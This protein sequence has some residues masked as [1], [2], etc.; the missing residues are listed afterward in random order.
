MLVVAAGG[1]SAPSN[2]T[3]SCPPGTRATA[4][5]CVLD[6]DLVL[7]DTIELPSFTTLDCRGYRIL[8][9]AVGSGTTQA[10]YIPSAPA[11]AIAITGERGVVVRNCAIGAEGARFDFGVI[12]INS[13]DAGKDGH[14][15]HNNEI[16]ARDSAITFLRVDDAR[17]NNNVITWTNGSGIS[18]ARDSDRNRVNNNVM[19]SPGAPPAAFRLVPGGTF[20]NSFDDAIFMSS[21]HLQPLFNL[22]IGGKLFQ[23]PNSENGQYPGNEDNF[24]GS[25]HLSL[26]GPS[27]GKSHAG[28][29]V[30]ANAARARLIGNTVSGAGTGIRLAG[31][32]PEQSVTRPGRCVGEPSRFCLTN[33]DC[34]IP[35]IDAAPV[36]TCTLPITEVR[37]LRARDTV[38][39]DNRLYGPFNSTAVPLRTAIFG[40]AGTV[41]GVIRG[42]LIYG[43][44]TEAGITLVGEMLQSGLVMG[45]AVQGASFGILLQQSIATSFDARV[46]LN[47]I[48]GSSTRAIGVFGTYTLPTELSWDGIGNYWG[49]LL[50]PCFN[51][52]DTP[53]PGLIQDSYPFCV[54]VAAPK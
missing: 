30:S 29:L 50:P 5:A 46:F 20:G 2:K 43:T 9:S 14:R 27:A 45:N 33:A 11:L 12:A 36:G 16:H 13:K 18:F 37:D 32:M 25:N 19:S 53:I 17:V 41:G 26:P 6:A 7:S 8:P 40:G 31:L 35:G 47:D 52:S 21:F 42:N 1:M 15:I 44:G 22:V 48:T 38:V 3:S 39:E 51:S 49:H 4:S 54:P 24:V 34:F 23:F 10:S 28:I